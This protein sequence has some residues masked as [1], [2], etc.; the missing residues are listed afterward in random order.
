M[1]WHKGQLL[2]EAVLLV[3]ATTRRLFDWHK[4]LHKKAYPARSCTV[5]LGLQ[6]ELQLLNDRSN[7]LLGCQL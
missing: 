3:R 1:C 6:L 2:L 4:K 7:W 5:W